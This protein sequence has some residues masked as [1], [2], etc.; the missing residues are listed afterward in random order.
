MNICQIKGI[1]VLFGAGSVLELT[2]EQSRPRA[3]NLHDLGDNRFEVI[4]PVEFRNGEI[5]GVSGAIPLTLLDLLEVETGGGQ[6]PALEEMTQLELLSIAQD[7]GLKPNPSTGKPKL[8]AMI[9]ADQEARKTP[10]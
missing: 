1:K 9:K 3:H 5:L 4:H 10:A 7:L 6:E 8:L 2:S